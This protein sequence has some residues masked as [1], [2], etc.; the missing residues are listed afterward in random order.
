MYVKKARENN[1]N[2]QII[3][4]RKV[5]RVLRTV[6]FYGESDRTRANEN[7]RR[8]TSV[9]LIAARQRREIAYTILAR[10]RGR[11]R[12]RGRG[13]VARSCC[14]VAARGEIRPGV[15]GVGAPPSGGI[16]RESPHRFGADRNSHFKMWTAATTV[17]TVT[18]LALGAWAGDELPRDTEPVA[19]GLRL[20]PR[21]DPVADQYA[22]G[23]N[24]DIWIRVNAIT[25]VV[26]LHA[27]DL[28]IK[29]VAIVESQTQVSVPVDYWTMLADQER[30]VIYP[31]DHLLAG[32]VYQVRIVYRGLLRTDTTGFYRSLYTENGQ[33][34]YVRTDGGKEGGERS[35]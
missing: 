11:V 24:V 15:T 29:S 5:T 19:Y 27:R 23:G 28:Q 34:K 20:A 7:V 26:T 21:Y 33:Q 1:N 3:S 12:W 10:V 17:V 22:Y 30:L 9:R 32:R 16:R 4:N 31:G 25:S 13:E 18:A 35:V 6:C 8:R 14:R 2:E